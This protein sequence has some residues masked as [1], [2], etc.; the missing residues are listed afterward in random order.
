MKTL[1]LSSLFSLS[2]LAV[3]PCENL[4]VHA[5][6]IRVETDVSHSC[7]P[8]FDDTKNR[9]VIRKPGYAGLE[10]LAQVAAHE[11]NSRKWCGPGGHYYV[12]ANGRI[13]QGRPEEMKGANEIN[14]ADG[15]KNKLGIQVLL[16][17]GQTK[18]SA[19]FVGNFT[20]LLAWQ[21]KKH[22]I[23]AGDV[24]THF[25]ADFHPGKLVQNLLNQFLTPKED[26]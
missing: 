8:T 9:I 2:V 15:N 26:L 20:Q 6:V 13:T 18:L 11:T 5:S 16:P 10:T 17:E 3:D 1:F 19:Y 12:D 22:I 4:K 24:K 7:K 23:S 21:M 25:Y 14:G